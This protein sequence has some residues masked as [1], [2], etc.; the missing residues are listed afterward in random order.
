M[1]NS[2]MLNNVEDFLCKLI[3]FP[4]TPGKELAAMEFLYQQFSKFNVEIQKIPLDNSLK[5]DLEYSSPIPDIDYAGRYN[6]RVVRKG[7]GSGKAIIFN[8][9]V[10]V[11]PASEG[12]DN[13]FVGIAKDGKIFG[14][15]A[16]DTKGGVATAYTLLAM[17]DDNNV[18]IDGDLIIHLVVEEENGGNG[19]L[20]MIRHSEKADGCVVLE[21]TEM[22]VLT[23]IR[24]AV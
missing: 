12:M 23:S 3:R 1:T 9:H 6:L 4:S 24:G 22:N 21:P 10:D 18:T 8:A 19:T 7:R 20:A 17:L 2:H 14:R 11:V 16:C 13:A 5:A 15:G